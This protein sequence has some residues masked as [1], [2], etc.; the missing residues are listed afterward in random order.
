MIKRVR[1]TLWTLAFGAAFLP[2]RVHAQADPNDWPMY[3]RD[4]IGTRFNPAET[5][6]GKENVGGLVEKWRFPAKG[7][8]ESIGVVH[9][10]PSVVNGQPRGRGAERRP[11]SNNI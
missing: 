7:S 3:N 5:A 2:A 4:V 11:A 8:D 1:T 6:I 9:A 10:T